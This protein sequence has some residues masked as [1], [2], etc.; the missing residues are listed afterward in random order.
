MKSRTFPK[1]H[2]PDYLIY[3]EMK[4]RRERDAWQPDYLEL[5]L[6]RPEIP[7]RNPT[8]KYEDPKPSRI[9]DEASA[10]EE[11]P[12]DRGVMIIDMND[13]FE[14]DDDEDL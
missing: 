4:R 2:I 10:P 12:G 9:G 8:K 1:T 3:D 14:D 5:P 7:T 11:T 6:Y 13:M